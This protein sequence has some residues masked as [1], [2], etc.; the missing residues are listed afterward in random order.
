MQKGR[1]SPTSLKLDFIALGVG[2]RFLELAEPEQVQLAQFL[3]KK[4]VASVVPLYSWQC[5]TAGTL[6]RKKSQYNRVMCLL[7]VKPGHDGSDPLWL[8]PLPCAEGIRVLIFEEEINIPG[9]LCWCWLV[10][11]ELSLRRSPH[12]FCQSFTS[13]TPIWQD[14]AV[15]GREEDQHINST[16]PQEASQGT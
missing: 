14:T 1:A 9:P 7:G 13:C 4:D 6:S 2:L 3:A 12:L 8:H 11:E 10:L 16:G 5:W 15:L